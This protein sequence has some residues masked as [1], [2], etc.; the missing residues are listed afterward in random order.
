MNG[1]VKVW[2]VCCLICHLTDASWRHI[3]VL[4]DVRGPLG[5]RKWGEIEKQNNKTQNKTPTNKTFTV[6]VSI[7]HFASLICHDWWLTHF[8]AADCEGGKK[9]NK[10]S[11]QLNLNTH[12]LFLWDEKVALHWNASMFALPWW[13]NDTIVVVKSNSHDT[14]LSLDMWLEG[15]G[16]KLTHKINTNKV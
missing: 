3:P 7:W 14:P 4:L 5:G 8:T 2:N 16:A 11:H 15:E 10:T 9:S 6:W 13:I 1:G 12:F